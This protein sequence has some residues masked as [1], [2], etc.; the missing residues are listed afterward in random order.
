MITL[1]VLFILSACSNPL[2]EEV[3][4]LQSTIKEYEKSLKEKEDIIAGLDKQIKS[5]Q[6]E[7]STELEKE[8]SELQSEISQKDQEINSLEAKVQLLMPYKEQ[9][10]AI[11][12]SEVQ[13]AESRNNPV[14]VTIDNFSLS[15]SGD[16]IVVNGELK[17]ISD[18]TLSS[19]TLRAIFTDSEGN[20]IDS[21]D[22]LAFTILPN[23]LTKYDTMVDYDA[24]IE[25]VEIQVVDFRF[26]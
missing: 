3:T 11:E 25:N 26:E 7:T 10:E 24:R 14:E 2:Q 17:N 21:Q 15:G 13:A 12:A 9:I 19:V 4:T 22:T 1:L 16:Y 5:L 20:I 18:S 8:I 6:S 23:G